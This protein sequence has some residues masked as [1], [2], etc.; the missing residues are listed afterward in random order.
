MKQKKRLPRYYA[1]R[2][3]LQ[4]LL[5]QLTGHDFDFIE[6]ASGGIR[7][8]TCHPSDVAACRGFLD[9]LYDRSERRFFGT[10]TDAAIH[11]MAAWREYLATP[12]TPARRRT[13]KKV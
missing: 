4:I 5:K 8:V 2:A 1:S 7:S 9:W 13:E 6:A 3:I 12:G 10:F 11:T